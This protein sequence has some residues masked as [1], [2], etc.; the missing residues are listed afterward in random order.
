MKII[1]ISWPVSANIAE[2][3][4][5]KIIQITPFGQEYI[6]G[7]VNHTGTHVDGP[8]SFFPG[9]KTIDQ[10]ELTKLTGK[11]QVLDLTAVENYITKKELQG[12]SINSD[13]II[14][15]KTQN[16]NLPTEGQFYDDFV[17]LA[18]SGAQYL[19]SKKVKAV[20]IDYI[21]LETL[22]D[23][24]SHKS[25]LHEEILIIEGLR[26]GHVKPGTYNFICL[27]VKLVGVDAAFAR[28]ILIEE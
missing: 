28:A 27:P 18:E 13:E 6:I 9:S 19:A 10:F 20:G 22:P 25:L 15:F 12:F 8:A 4:N 1:D 7:M 21:A 2:Y 17:Y 23:F 3:E 11:C 16:S 5:R 14:L 24:P 26:L